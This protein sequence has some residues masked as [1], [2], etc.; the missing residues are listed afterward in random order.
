MGHQEFEKSIVWL[1]V[2]KN[3]FLSLAELVR[4]DCSAFSLPWGLI[5][6]GLRIERQIG[7]LVRK[8]I[9]AGKLKVPPEVDIL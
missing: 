4:I 9:A 1:A 3:L 6:N 2:V 5:R 7:H 8:I